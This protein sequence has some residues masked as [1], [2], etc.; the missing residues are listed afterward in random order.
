MGYFS[1]ETRR[2]AYPRRP[3]GR[4]ILD[5]TPIPHRPP[6]PTEPAAGPVPG[7]PQS[8]LPQS[9]PLIAR[10]RLCR[11]GWT[12][13]SPGIL[14]ENREGAS[15]P[16]LVNR[17]KTAQKK[18]YGGILHSLCTGSLRRRLKKKVYF[19]LQT[20]CISSA[21]ECWVAALLGSTGLNQGKWLSKMSG[22][23]DRPN[24]ALCRIHKKRQCGWGDKIANTNVNTSLWRLCSAGIDLGNQ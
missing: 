6:A 7:P 13:T 20:S 23:R 16:G 10:Q 17:N 14:T 19:M 15:I 2:T 24:C 12:T 21:Q 18:H 3:G 4:L 22:C 11:Q 9:P 5:M 1:L 8:W